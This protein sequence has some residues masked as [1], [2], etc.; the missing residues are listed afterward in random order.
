MLLLMPKLTDTAVKNFK[1]EEEPYSRYDEDGLYVIVNPNGSKWWRV[2]YEFDGRKNTLTAGVYPK[3]TLGM[4]RKERDRIKQQLA[5][6][7]D[8]S[9]ERK[10]KKAEA[11][12]A[13][14][15]AAN[16]FKAVALAYV[17]SKENEWAASNMKKKMRLLDKLFAAIGDKPITTVAF[18]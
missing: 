4:A 1:P 11:Q 18:L 17:A 10:R 14:A 3:V 9:A 6:G 12:Q 16:T 15:E 5:Q 7:I 8:P 2:R 13:E